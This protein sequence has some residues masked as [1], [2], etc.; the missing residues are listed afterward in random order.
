MSQFMGNKMKQ[1]LKT[2]TRR[3][4]AEARLDTL[5]E[6]LGLKKG[7]NGNMLHLDNAYGGYA[8][9]GYVG[10]QDDKTDYDG[11][12]ITDVSLYYTGRQS[13]PKTIDILNT[14]IRS[15]EYAN[16]IKS[17]NK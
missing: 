5:N 3:E 13:L 12:C 1:E 6:L 10:C 17:D 8:I 9:V 2:P 15:I 7:K 11:N 16:R 4:I 14:M